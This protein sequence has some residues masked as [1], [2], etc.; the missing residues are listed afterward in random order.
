MQNILSSEMNEEKI[1]SEKIVCAIDIGTS[2][3]EA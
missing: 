3:V 1:D 2:K